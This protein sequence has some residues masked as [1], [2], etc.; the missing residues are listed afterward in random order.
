M[1]PA[2]TT[3]TQLHHIISRWGDLHDAL[4]D[5]QARQWPP[6]MGISRLVWDD[7]QREA[8]RAERLD[9]NPDAPGPRPMPIS[10]DILDTIREIEGALVHC[11]DVI[12]AEI[13]RP[14]M[15]PAP[16]GAGW[17][18]AE[19]ARRDQLAADDAADLRR[20]PWPSRGADAEGR[21]VR[22]ERA[23]GLEYRRTAPDA[24]AWLAARIDAAPG[25]FLPLGGIRAARIGRVATWAATRLDTALREARRTTSAGRPCPACRSDRLE[26]H[27]GDGQPPTVRCA[28]CG[29]TWTERQSAAA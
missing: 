1:P 11:A 10:A 19:V 17:T 5:Q 8:H 9:T 6:V 29:R 2:D 13:Q 26:V 12:A 20:W 27:G 24:A 21:R 15:G 3:L 4:T 23:T 16:R 18:P 28:D 7:D 14:A 25:P 22:P